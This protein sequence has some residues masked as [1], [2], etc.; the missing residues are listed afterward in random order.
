M[1]QENRLYVRQQINIS[2]IS[3]SR[4]NVYTLRTAITAL[5]ISGLN[6]IVIKTF[7]IKTTGFSDA[8]KVIS[9]G[10]AMADTENRRFM[11]PISLKRSRAN[12]L[13]NKNSAFC[14]GIV[15]LVNIYLIIFTF[16]AKLFTR[17]S[18]RPSKLNRHKSSSYSQK[19]LT[20]TLNWSNKGTSKYQILLLVNSC[21]H[22][23]YLRMFRLFN[24]S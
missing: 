19:I 6:K 7:G 12:S 13:A 17:W 22:V 3:R 9:E 8:L 24:T 21:I 4:T 2:R 16:F 5:R 20:L 14:K 18:F 23:G 1:K 11:F 15:F 10:T